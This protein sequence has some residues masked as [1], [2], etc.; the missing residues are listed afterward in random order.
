MSKKDKIEKSGDKKVK[1]TEATENKA[2]KVSNKIN[3]GKCCRCVYRS[4]KE[5]TCSNKK[6]PKAGKYVARKGG[7]NF[8]KYND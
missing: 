1:E 2:E 7:C 5:K 3:D 6:S 8:F 4:T